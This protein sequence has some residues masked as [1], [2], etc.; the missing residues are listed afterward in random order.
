MIWVQLND[1]MNTN[2]MQPNLHASEVKCS[3]LNQSER[4]QMK[5]NGNECIWIIMN[6]FEWFWINVNELIEIGMSLNKYEWIW[7]NSN[8]Q[9]YWVILRTCLNVLNTPWTFLTRKYYWMFLNIEW[10]FPDEGGLVANC[11]LSMVSPLSPPANGCPP[12]H[13]RSMV[14][15]RPRPAAPPAREFAILNSE[16]ESRFPSQSLH[17]IN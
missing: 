11:L 7:M 13:P 1:S 9:M 8:I 5:L 3:L 14:P 4:I 10:R 17:S 15:G 16:V 12:C 2:G 6:G